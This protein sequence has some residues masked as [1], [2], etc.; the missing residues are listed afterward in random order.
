MTFASLPFAFFF[1]NPFTAAAAACGVVAIPVIIHLLNRRR[2]KI[3][4]WAAMRFLLVAQKKSSRRMRI[5]QLLLLVVRCLI[6][7][8]LVLAMASVT[9][10]AESAWRWFA[11]EG[12]KSYTSGGARVHKIIVIDGSF[13]MSLKSNKTN[14]FLDNAIGMGIQD[15]G[16]DAPCFDWARYMAAK[17]V[18]D[19]PSGDGFSVVLMGAP[20]RR[21]VPEPSDDGRRVIAEIA[22]MRMPHGNADL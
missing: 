1:A 12:A 14:V 15:K 9:G 22:G 3:V 11:P 21:V 10:W 6:V 18:K 13:S 8:L 17:I 7:L 16:K 20:P 19:S 2:F 4:Q 5:E